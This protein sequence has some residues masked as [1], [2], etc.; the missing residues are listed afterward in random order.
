MDS[1]P[2]L[3]VLRDPRTGVA[4]V[5]LAVIALVAALYLARAFFVPL[6]IGILVSYALSPLVDW[7]KSH[8]VPG[9]LA[10]ALVLAAL[11]G[12]L[13]WVAVTLNDQAVAMI[14]KLPDAAHKLRESLVVARSGGPTSLQKLQEAANEI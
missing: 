7:L 10:A 13:S 12:G 11:V 2:A 1:A 8:R 5:V 4:V 14:E 6:L 9:P 3:R